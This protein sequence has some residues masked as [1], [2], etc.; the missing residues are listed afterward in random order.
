MSNTQGRRWRRITTA[1]CV[2]T[3]ALAPSAMAQLPNTGIEPETGTP[4][5]TIVG[6][7]GGGVQTP[8]DYVCDENHP[9]VKSI[10]SGV[11]DSL[12]NTFPDITTMLARGYFPYADAPLFGF[13]GRQGH[14]INPNY[15]QDVYP[16]GHPKAGQPRLMDPYHPESILV[17]RWNRPI[18]VMFIA[19]D[20]YVPGPDMYVDEETGEACNGWHYHT[21]IMADTYWYA[22]KYGW[23]GDLTS[24]D[25]EKLTLPDRTPDLMHV[26]RY[27]DYKDQWNHAAPPQDT[28]PGD[29]AS[30]Q[31]VKGI[32]GGPR[33]PG[34]PPPPRK[35]TQAKVKLCLAKQ[36]ASSRRQ[37]LTKVRRCGTKAKRR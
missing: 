29:P 7:L 31:D 9:V 21:E 34:T 35:R 27:G 16:A 12:A 13:S 10:I 4:V 1:A 17:D 32:I 24:G 28:M 23:S 33:L 14:W 19:D 15:I 6:A 25:P 5:D 2:A 26:W 3:M 11:K 37:G 30:V 22:Y 36:T 20:P 8:H 18:G